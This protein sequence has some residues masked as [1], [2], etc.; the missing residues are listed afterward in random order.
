MSDGSE[1]RV[2]KELLDR[3]KALP[4]EDKLWLKDKL[5]IIVKSETRKKLRDALIEGWEFTK[6]IS[7]EQIEK[8]VLEEIQDYRRNKKG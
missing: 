1:K 6:D 8:E 3:V 7:P 4:L 2:A 5:D